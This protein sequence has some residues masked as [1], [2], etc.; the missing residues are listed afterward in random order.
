MLKKI[1]TQSE[2]DRKRNRNQFLIGGILI[3]ILVV[4]TAGFSLMSSDEESNSKAKEQGLTFY[5]DSGLW[6]TSFDDQVFG[7]KYLPSEVENISVEGTYDL[8]VYFDKPLYYIGSNEGVSEILSNIG[9]Y[10]LRYQEA[11]LNGTVCERDLPVKNCDENL[12][13][14]EESDETRVYQ[15]GNCV[16]IFGDSIKGADMFLYKVLKVN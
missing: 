4:S 2:V 14:F 5:K 13:I 15:D 7:F 9:K 8:G 12:I 16:Y 11:C 3:L 10:A 1:K 6:K